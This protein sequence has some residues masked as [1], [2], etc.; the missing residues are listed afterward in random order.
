MKHTKHPYSDLQ[1]SPLWPVVEK[2]LRDLAKNG[3]FELQTA[4]PYVVGYVTRAL[5]EA[6]FQQVS[7]VRHGTRVLRV[8]EVTKKAGKAANVA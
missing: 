2:A 6:G 1:D 7:Q 3:D 4:E 5:E 8:V